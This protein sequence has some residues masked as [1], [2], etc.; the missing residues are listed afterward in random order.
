M[1][2]ESTTQALAILRDTSQFSWYVIPLL[3]IVIYVYA[4]E[5]DKGNWSRVLAGLAFWGMDWFNEIWNSLVFHFSQYA[6][7]WA[8]PSDTAYLIFIGLN[9]EICFMFAISGIVATLALPKDPKIKI[10]GL[11]NRWFF[12]VLFSLLSVLVEITLNRIGAL[13]WDWT[14]WNADAPWLLFLVGYMSFYSICYWVYDMTSRRK[15]LQVIGGLYG[16]NITAIVVFG[17]ILGW[18]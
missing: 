8:A 6:P 16:I 5:A 1:P 10:L 13:T 4:Q 14:W 9:I 3:L 11:N 2:T 7:V 15:Q 17:G 18:L 12:A